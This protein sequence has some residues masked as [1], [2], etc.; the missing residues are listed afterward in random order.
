MSNQNLPT[1]SFLSIFL[2]A[3]EEQEEELQ[4]QFFAK[5]SKVD[6]ISA[7]NEG[8]VAAKKRF[9]QSANPYPEYSDKSSYSQHLAWNEGWMSIGFSLDSFLLK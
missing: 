8:V 4:A 7:F 3:I 5:C 1:D 2:A 9:P 6:L